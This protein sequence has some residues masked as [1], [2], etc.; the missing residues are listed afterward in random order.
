MKTLVLEAQIVRDMMADP[1]FFP[2]V[3]LFYFMK[4]VAAA[5]IERLVTC[6]SCDASATVRDVLLR[7]VVRMAVEI[8]PENPD[9]LKPLRTYLAGR[10]DEPGLKVVIPY[11]DA[12]GR[13]ALELMP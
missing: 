13:R 5:T 1:G 2:A 7:P 4:D 10:L 3:P 6:T 12:R 8:H 9:A 11:Q